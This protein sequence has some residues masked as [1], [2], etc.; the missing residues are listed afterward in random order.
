[1][2][3]L[4]NQFI[5]E[6]IL[7]LDEIIKRIISESNEQPI[8]Q[9]SKLQIEL[10][11]YQD[12]GVLISREITLHIIPDYNEELDKIGIDIGLLSMKINEEAWLKVA[13][14]RHTVKDNAWEY[15]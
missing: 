7:V 10:E 3:N 12:D 1:M 14:G 13:P 11:T 15:I 2:E 8:Y 4:T 9:N 5:R 6:E